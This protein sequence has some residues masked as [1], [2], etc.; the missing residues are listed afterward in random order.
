MRYDILLFDAD[1]TLFD[2]T[3]GEKA[4]FTEAMNAN[5]VNVEEGMVERYSEINE[6]CWKELER[7][8]IDKKTLVVKRYALFLQHYRLALDAAKVN[9]DYKNALATQ[10]ILIEGALEL[11][12]R[13]SEQAEVYIITNG[14]TEVQKGRF[15]RSPITGYIKKIFISEQMDCKKPDKLFFDMVEREIP[16]FEKHRAVVIGDSL[17]SDIQGANNAGIDAVWYNPEKKKA[18]AGYRIKK[19][20]SSFEELEQFLMGD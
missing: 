14:L 7:G 2:F 19:T 3:A 20:V 16:G 17:T 10:A 6:R 5:G 9:E 8:E 15:S 18:P 13:L 11:V 12:K 1:N 4:A